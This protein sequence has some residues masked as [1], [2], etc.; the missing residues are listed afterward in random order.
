MYTPPGGVLPCVKQ[1]EEEA[2]PI[3]HHHPCHKTVTDRTGQGRAAQQHGSSPGF[4]PSRQCRRSQ[5][6]P[7]T[8]KPAAKPAMARSKLC[9]CLTH[10]TSWPPG[11][12]GV[13]SDAGSGPFGRQ[14]GILEPEAGRRQARAGKQ[15]DPM[16]GWVGGGCRGRR[17]FG[18]V[19]GSVLRTERAIVCCAPGFRYVPEE[20]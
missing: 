2:G 1:D 20:T 17:Q 6:H 7:K 5:S 3:H 11:S 16:E 9:F 15:K 14:H 19:D 12:S 8:C 13:S 4:V 18:V 10:C